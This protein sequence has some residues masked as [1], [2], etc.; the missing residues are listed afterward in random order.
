MSWAQRT[1]DGRPPVALARWGKA[2]VEAGGFGS[3]RED[4]IVTSPPE[5]V[6]AMAKVGMKE[7]ELLG[8]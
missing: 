1:D 3:R 6:G 7:L 5:L 4:P 8:L 2:V